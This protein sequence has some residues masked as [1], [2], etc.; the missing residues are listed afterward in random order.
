MQY[1]KHV[2]VYTIIYIF[3]ILL[4]NNLYGYIFVESGIKS[5]TNSLDD[6]ISR[7]KYN[8]IY[9]SNDIVTYSHEYTH[10]VNNYYRQKYIQQFPNINALYMLHDNICVIREPQFTLR[11]IADKIPANMRGRNYNLYLIQQTKYWNSQPLYILDELIAYSNG[12][13]VGFE[14]NKIDRASDSAR[15]AAEFFV[16]TVIL[17]SYSHDYDLGQFIIKYYKEYN[18]IYKKANCMNMILQPAIIKILYDDLG[19][20]LD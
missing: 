5:Y 16:Y 19:M 17:F 20:V 8:N 15:S 18:Y 7:T 2:Y 9:Y 12:A 10:Y 4:C 14:N 13:V 3:C 6:I 1:R 11:F